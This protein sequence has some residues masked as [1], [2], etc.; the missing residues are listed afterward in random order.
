[1]KATNE[2][3]LST[4]QE[5]ATSPPLKR[6][7]RTPLAP[8]ST[9]ETTPLKKTPKYERPDVDKL[10]LPEIR[11][12]YLRLEGNHKKL[13]GKYL[14]AMDARTELDHRLREKIK[15]IE[16]WMKHANELNAQSQKRLRKIKRL[17]VQLGLV[18]GNTA[19]Y[20]A[21]FS[22]DTSDKVPTATERALHT[23][24]PKAVGNS[25]QGGLARVQADTD[26]RDFDHGPLGTGAGQITLIS[27]QNSGQKSL[28]GESTQASTR[29]NSHM[30]DPPSLPPLPE[31]RDDL[32]N[33]IRIKQ[34]PPSDTPVVVSERSVRKRRRDDDEPEH[35]PASTRVKTEDSDPIVFEERRRFAPQESM[36]FD[37]EVP[38]VRTP[39]KNRL[40]QLQEGGIEDTPEPPQLQNYDYYPRERR[41][42][43]ERSPSPR[44]AI[45][46]VRQVDKFISGSRRSRH[47]P[48]R[49]READS[50]PPLTTERT[51][52]RP[53][54]V[55][56]LPD[57]ISRGSKAK[58][59]G[60]ALI[61]QG[62]DSLAEDGDQYQPSRTSR[63]LSRGQRPS[64]ALS[65]LLNVP[66]AE[67]GAGNA[68]PATTEPR[69]LPNSESRLALSGITALQ[70]PPKRD[71]PFS[72]GRSRRASENLPQAKSAARP[73][74]KRITT[75]NQPKSKSVAGGGDHKDGD[76]EDDVNK[77]VSLPPA[78][79]RANR[80]NTNADTNTNS[81][82]TGTG[83]S[84][85][86]AKNRTPLRDRGLSQLRL[87]DFKVNPAANEG[88]GYAFTDVV[89][90]HAE[91]A[92]SLVGCVR[93]SCCGAQFRTLARAERPLTGPVEF[94]ALLESY[95]DGDDAAV[96]RL[97]AMAPDEREA[98]WLEAKTREL[99]DRHGRCRHRYQRMPSPPGFWRTEFPSTQ[100]LEEDRAQGRRMEAE[101]VQERYREAMRPGGRWLF[102]DE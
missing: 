71:L 4:K 95:L 14:E 72:K 39:R 93:E 35:K 16:Q 27:R 42:S 18:G 100:Q 60:P 41:N 32:Q 68:P 6:I 69:I 90:N 61:Q 102:R 54:G 36:D 92:H 101:M 94:Q 38:H 50:T 23:P 99:A 46:E 7:T 87:D 3:L 22:S 62:L 5:N 45:V 64:K 15:N 98:L 33:M 20:A 80:G 74:P 10:K 28:G 1:M 67:R 75:A 24:H 34:E 79:A 83:A 26:V 25:T 86:A 52:P 57:R 70:V 31:N 9:N 40:K 55:N 2:R 51:P 58:S 49:R 37:A 30:E 73:T 53:S 12:E 84:A 65:D 11:E 88:Y 13:H 56:V 59:G 96:A 81:T 29:E 43:A 21:S 66:P 77:T 44:E 17:E 91:R 48:R 82:G 8:R 63:S 89:R 97:P 76:R 47:E 85:A 78:T 19:G